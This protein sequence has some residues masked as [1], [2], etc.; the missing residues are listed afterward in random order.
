MKFKADGRTIPR[1]REPMAT[2]LPVQTEIAVESEV[3]GKSNEVN[4]IEDVTNFL[5]S[6]GVNQYAEQFTLNEIDGRM[7]RSLSSQEL[8]DDLH[9]KSLRDR[10]VILQAVAKLSASDDDLVV[11]ICDKLP[12]H[13]RIL[14]HLSNVRTY[15]SWLRVGVQFL[16][17]SIVT[18]RLAPDFRNTRLVSAAASYFA[19]VAVLALLY[20]IF[21]Y[22]K[23]IT[24]IENSRLSDP[25]Y[26]PDAIGTASAVVLIIF[27]AILAIVMIAL[28]A[29]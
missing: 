7:L 22:R 13:G 20:A 21:R 2:L 26:A 29:P 4:S 28:P 5:R 24:M 16:S 23:V 18:L 12:E 10:R 15:H 14:D 17:F 19:T 8:R 25:T 6:I 27:A 3:P 11:D 9:V 1:T